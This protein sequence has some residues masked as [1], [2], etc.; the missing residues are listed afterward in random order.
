MCPKSNFVTPGRYLR[1][2]LSLSSARASRRCI[3]SWRATKWPAAVS[4]G[5]TTDRF[6]C[7]ALELSLSLAFLLCCCLPPSFDQHSMRAMRAMAAFSR[8]SCP[9]PTRA[10]LATDRTSIVILLAYRF[11]LCLPPVFR[12]WKNLPFPLLSPPLRVST[13][14]SVYA[15]WKL[16]R[17]ATSFSQIPIGSVKRKDA[18]KCI[19]R[20][21]KRNSYMVCFLIYVSNV[22]DKFSKTK[23]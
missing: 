2:S 20:N 4:A 3:I 18:A 10:L 23:K 1:A 19:S 21:R 8:R 7:C 22:R 11:P 9:W 16:Y 17:C 5:K 15:L 13:H 12:A 14:L 6:R